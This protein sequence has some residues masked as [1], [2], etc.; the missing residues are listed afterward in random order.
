M[1]HK[2]ATTTNTALNSIINTSCTD[3]PTRNIEDT[4]TKTR[5]AAATTEQVTS[6]IDMNTT[7]TNLGNSTTNAPPLER[8]ENGYT[9]YTGRPRTLLEIQHMTDLMC[10]LTNNP[11][12]ITSSRIA[13]EWISRTLQERHGI[14][15]SW[16]SIARYWETRGRASTGIDE[17]KVA[18]VARKELAVR[19]CFQWWVWGLMVTDRM[20]AGGVYEG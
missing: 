7:P 13:A 9:H 15:R 6:N 19:F 10:E 12:I 3:E 1:D 2:G 16:G 14:T 4:V 18:S 17:R 11:T 20:L 8:D 5:N